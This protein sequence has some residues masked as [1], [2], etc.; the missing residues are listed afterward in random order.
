MD[1]EKLINF[2][3]YYEFNTGNLMVFIR[4]YTEWLPFYDQLISCGLDFKHK[5][6]QQLEL[7]NYIIWIKRDLYF[8]L[9]S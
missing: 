5:K 2:I 6:D 4:N 8:L 1:K 9:D 7:I 3:N